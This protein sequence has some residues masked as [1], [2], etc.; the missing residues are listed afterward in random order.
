MDN[1][2]IFKHLRHAFVLTIEVDGGAEHGAG[3]VVLA[4]AH[5]AVV[6]AAAG[7]AYNKHYYHAFNCGAA[8]PQSWALCLQMCP[9]YSHGDLLQ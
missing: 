9:G 2:M 5:Y 8:R 3:S 7:H 4:P 1:I 6:A